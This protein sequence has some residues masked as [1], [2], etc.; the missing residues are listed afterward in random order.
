MQAYIPSKNG[1]F[2][3]NDSIIVNILLVYLS[4]YIST[5]FSL[6]FYNL[7]YHSIFIF[8]PCF[9]RLFSDSP[10]SRFLTYQL[11]FGCPSFILH[12]F[13][14]RYFFSLFLVSFSTPLILQSHRMFSILCVSLCVESHQ[15]QTT[16]IIKTMFDLSAFQGQFF[17]F[18]I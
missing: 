18:Y 8:L 3:K 7:I 4:L 1:S 6:L 10:W 5:R 17:L 16:S 13:L 9:I 11:R 2:D 15:Q 14:A 12:I